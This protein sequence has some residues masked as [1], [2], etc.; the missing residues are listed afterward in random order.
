MADDTTKPITDTERIERLEQAL[1]EITLQSLGQFNRRRLWLSSPNLR[2][3]IE[4][5]TGE[6]I[7]LEMG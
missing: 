5:R 3:L 7:D 1:T 4:E 6:T 2:A